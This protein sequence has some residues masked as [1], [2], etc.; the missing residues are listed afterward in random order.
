MVLGAVASA[1][2]SAAGQWYVGGLKFTGTESIKAEFGS[3]TYLWELF[4]IKIS[5]LCDDASATG[6]ISE[7]NKDELEPVKLSECIVKEPS[8]CT[9]TSVETTSLKSELVVEGEHVY[10]KDEPV[11]GTTLATIKISGCSVEG[12][13]VI[14]GT[15]RC[16]MASTEST[17]DTCEYTASSGSKLKVAKG[18]S[19]A[20]A[21]YEVSR[22][23]TLTGT[24]AGDSWGAKTS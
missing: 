4:N 13:Y 5:I 19:S 24:D 14:S 20:E 1:S 3:T 11:S 7:S 16:L 15:T 17:A 8:G 12:T 23:T 22:K 6:S 2:A 18:E 21:S 10:D 9:V